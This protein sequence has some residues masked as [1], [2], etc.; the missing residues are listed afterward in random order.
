MDALTRLLATAQAREAEGDR[1]AA[2]DVLDGAPGPL[3]ERALW[4]Y[5]RAALAFRGG[6]LDL[7]LHHA[8]QAVAREPAIPEYRATLGAVLLERYQQGREQALLQRA[9]SE[10]QAAVAPGPLLPHAHAQLALAL[11]LAGRPAEALDCADA[12]LQKDAACV[13]ALWH[14]ALALEALGRTDE[15]QAAVQ[16]VLALKP[17]FAP[18]LARRPS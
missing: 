10:L 12:A 6:A 13:P 15:A 4:A 3:R 18:A 7:A 1:Q 5:A 17:D 9:L 16:R 14:R 2:C 8:E 11:L